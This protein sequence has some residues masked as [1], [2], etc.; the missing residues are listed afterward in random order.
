MR[1]KRKVEFSILLII[2]IIALGL[3]L[4]IY[5]LATFG[6]WANE[7]L[8][9]IQSED[10]RT[11][12]DFLFSTPPL[13]ATLLHF[14][15]Y[16]GESDFVFRL[17]PM[18]FGLLS[19]FAIYLVGKMLFDRKVAL[20][21]ALFLSISP[22]HIYYSQ[23]LRHYS[24]FAF[25]SLM[26]LYFLIRALREDRFNL[27]VGFVIFTSLCLYSHVFSFFTVLSEQ[28]I[29]LFFWAKSRRLIKKWLLCQF[30]LVLLYL[31]WLPVL[32]GKQ[33]PAGAD[34]LRI[35]M[36]QPSLRTFYQPFKCFSLGYG[37]IKGQYPFA[38]MLFGST[39]GLSFI[40]FK[41]NRKGLATLWVFL[42]VP[43]LS[44]FIISQ[45]S[46]IYQA[47]DL[48]AASSAYY[49]LLAV[50]VSSIKKRF[51]RD[52]MLISMAFLLIPSLYNHYIN[53]TF[54]APGIYPKKGLREAALYVKSNFRT[55]DLIGHSEFLTFIPFGYYF[56]AEQYLINFYGNNTYFFTFLLSTKERFPVWYHKQFEDTRLIDIEEFVTKGERIW[57]IL[58][59]WQLILPN[60][61]FM[62]KDLKFTNWPKCIS[63]SIKGWMDIQ[64][65]VVDHKSFS[66]VEVFLYAPYPSNHIISLQLFDILPKYELRE[67]AIYVKS[68]FR[69]GDMIVH[70]EYAT[71][72]PFGH[73]FGGKQYIV[74]F[75]G[76][77]VMG[78]S[79]LSSFKKICP[80]LYE[81]IKDSEV[82][83][84]EELAIEDKRIW[85]IFPNSQLAAPD[86][87]FKDSSIFL[88]LLIKERMDSCYKLLD[89]KS[90]SDAEVLLYGK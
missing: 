80:E 3:G 84:I 65:K 24:L 14:W 37:A 77:G 38:L 8:S 29:F 61:Y 11:L 60:R 71:F 81:Q 9:A 47:K 22:F 57:L 44:A 5:H 30:L 87:K 51:V 83:D 10:L 75:H 56:K 41:E 26:S 27:W 69:P 45:F 1:T 62:T 19:I 73:Y 89:R 67:A 15:R 64:Y 74:D 70:S 2:L 59:Y 68:N 79:I 50:G 20:I 23:E 4:R 88:S 32:L 90:F 25:V 58:P 49:L 55:G 36:S 76:S 72:V 52:F 86:E 33:L 85:V 18:V 66:D 82:I 28:I 39:L 12:P 78:L 7:V 53:N 21:S 42:L 13:M 34:V 63:L 35:S 43:I 17:F 40:S 54:Q 48:I 6:F 31:P 46:P 16:L